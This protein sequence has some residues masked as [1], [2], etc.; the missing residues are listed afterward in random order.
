VALSGSAVEVIIR[1]NR[2]QDAG[3]GRPPMLG[4]AGTPDSNPFNDPTNHGDNSLF[5]DT[6]DFMNWRWDNIRD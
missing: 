3:I 6:F 4:F 5:G 1:A 2:G